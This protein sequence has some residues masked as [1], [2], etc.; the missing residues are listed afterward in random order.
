M[1]V[2]GVRRERRRDAEDGAEEGEEGE[3]S[4]Q[5][6]AVGL[7]ED[8]VLEETAEEED[9]EDS[10]DA[11]EEGVERGGD[12][13]IEEETGG[14]E[15]EGV[16]GAAENQNANGLEREGNSAVLHR[17][18]DV[19]GVGGRGLRVRV[20][21]HSHHVRQC[22]G[23][24]KEKRG[25]GKV[26][27]RDGGHFCLRIS[28]PPDS[29]IVGAKKCHKGTKRLQHDG[30]D[31]VEHVFR[32]STEGRKTAA[33]PAIQPQDDQ[34]GSQ[35]LRTLSMISPSRAHFKN[36]TGTDQMESGGDSNQDQ[37]QNGGMQLLVDEVTRPRRQQH[38]EQCD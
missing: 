3:E 35:K 7:V 10:E 9:E 20:Q 34:V 30:A 24:Y 37:S 19:L 26:P 6:E 1:V 29:H 38:Q 2:L 23:E 16:E 32:R 31:R 22:A 28:P 8:A 17:A 15:G 12:Q 14:V 18:V 36:G 21:Y 33:P 5:F 25:E 11:G 4:R 27:S 13:Q